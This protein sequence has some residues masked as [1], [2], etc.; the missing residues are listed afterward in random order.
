MGKQMSTKHLVFHFIKEWKGRMD[1]EHLTKLILLNDPASKWDQTHWAYY[2]TNI[3]SPRGRYTDLF[4]DEIK[5]NL[6]KESKRE[7]VNRPLHVREQNSGNVLPMRQSASTPWPAWNVPNEEEQRLLAKVLMRYIK[8]LHPDIVA[9][10]VA[11]NNQNMSYWSDA[12]KRIG[13]RA[14]IYLWKD[15]PV[16]FP[17]IR[18]HVGGKET[19]SFRA[20]PKECTVE[21][22]LRLDDNSF[23]KELWAF[24]LRNRRYG[25]KNPDN[26]SLAHIVDHKDHQTR[27]CNELI[28]FKESGDKNLFAGLYTSC[29]NAFY[30]PAVFMKPTDFNSPIRKLLIQIV[31]KYYGAICNPLPHGLQF[32]LTNLPDA[33]QLENFDLPEVVGNPA[34]IKSFLGYRKKAIESLIGKKLKNPE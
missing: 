2:R 18:R 9:Q 12:F 17:G 8:I 32:N 22:A 13:I 16:A 26:Y 6:L 10:V 28:G 34:H 3:T 27:N 24:A 11:N 4:S 30:V 29:V 19:V 5:Q 7:R 15:S 21:N 20:N 23:P 1:L 33:W 14:D 31:H 25:M